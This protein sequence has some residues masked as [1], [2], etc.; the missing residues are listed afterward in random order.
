MQNLM[1]SP[2]CFSKKKK[3]RTRAWG[4]I[5]TVVVGS[6]YEPVDRSGDPYTA[7]DELCLF[8]SR[9][10]LLSLLEEKTAVPAPGR[11]C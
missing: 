7:E 9:T 2:S 11:A 8:Y 3:R 5:E 1:K 4:T 10:I 6:N